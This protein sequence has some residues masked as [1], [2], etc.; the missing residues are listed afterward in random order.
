MN[1]RKLLGLVAS[2]ALVLAATLGSTGGVLAA[3]NTQYWAGN[4]TTNG[5]IDNNDCNTDSSA[6]QLWIWTGSA[7]GLDVWISVD[8]EVVKGVQQGNGAYHFTTGWH[9]IGDLTTGSGGNVFVT[10]DGTF[11]DNAVLTLSHGCPGETSSSSSSV[12]SSSSSVESSS[13]SVESSSS[14][15]ES[16]SSSVES[17]SSSVESSSS[18]VESSSSSVESSSSSVESSSSSSESHSQTVSGESSSITEPNTAT[19]GDGNSS[20]RGSAAWLLIAALGALFG[21]ILVLTPAKAKNRE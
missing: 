18:S 11:D 7:D 13:S 19:I 9:D 8:G 20:N 17:S 6:H 10:Y 16:S 15:V 3:A 5:E 21:S 14:S 2:G 1:K 12:E 4:G